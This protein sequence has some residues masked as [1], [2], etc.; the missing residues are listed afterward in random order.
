MK[1]SETGITEENQT[2]LEHLSSAIQIPTVSTE[3]YAETNF[4]PFDQY[5]EYLQSTFPL[6]FK[7]CELTKIEK[8]SLLFRWKGTGSDQKPIIFMSHFDVVPVQE[9]QWK[10]PPFSGAIAEGRV[11]GRG[12]LDT[13]SQHIAYLE[14]AEKLLAQGFTPKRDLYFS[15]GHDEEVGGMV[16]AESIVAHLEKTGLRFEGVIDE[17]G[18]IVKGAFNGVNSPVAVIGVAEKGRTEYKISVK[19]SGGHASMPPKLNAFTQVAEFVTRLNKRPLPTRL[20]PTVLEMLKC[21]SV[22]M[23]PLIRFAVNHSSIFGWLIKRILS[24]NPTTNAM[25]RTTFAPTKV[26]SSDGGNVLP[27]TASVNI[28]VRILEGDTI[29][30]VA[31]YFK[32]VAGDIPIE[33][34][35]V[36]ETEASA[37]SALRSDFLESI[38]S[39]I[40][41]F[42]PDA[43]VSPYLMV[44]GTDSRK[45]VTVA[46]N[47]YRFAP[48]YLEIEDQ[49]TLHNTNENIRIASYLKM[50]DFFESFFQKF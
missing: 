14:T 50:L 49:A 8:Y 30:S 43:I 20:T 39:S 18:L 11:W 28:D 5:L 13:K 32:K 24:Q 47:V 33:V 42:F 27:I 9:D 41:E 4:Q 17:G 34:S 7:T 48:V 2:A 45:F 37:V 21:L 16:G 22:E 10:Y 35:T 15:I 46:D 19:G 29:A 31:E 26:Q 23:S 1:L 38:K 25:I 6:F 40:N 12:T 44:G 36:T 3:V